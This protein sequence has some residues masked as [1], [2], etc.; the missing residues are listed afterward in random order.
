MKKILFMTAVVSIGILFVVS[1]SMAT[2]INPVGGGG[3]ELS[4]Q[5]VLNSITTAPISGTSSVNVNTDQVSPDAYWSIGGSGLSGITMI[6]E[7]AGWNASTTFGVFSGNNAV[8]IFGGG[9]SQGAQAVMSI[10][11][12]G[13]V[14]VNGSDT[15]VDFPGNLFG[16]Y[17]KTIG[18][19]NAIFYS[20]TSKNVDQFDH[21]V[22]FQGKGI[23][24]IQIPTLVPGLWGVSE[25]ALAFEDT[26]Y[27][28][29]WDYQDLVV[30]V[31]SVNPAVPE[32]ATMLLLGSG[33]LGLAGF[34]RKKFKK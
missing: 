20:D 11:A 5:A 23:D 25:F 29:D 33:L 18:Q 9:A 4:L 8:Q 15:L 1:A 16:Y 28:G 26:I 14:W 21:M 17:I 32:P 19:Q 6:I 7:L 31:E 24:T 13:S 3:A 10:K 34:A 12:D 22:A 27:G 30:M 2:P